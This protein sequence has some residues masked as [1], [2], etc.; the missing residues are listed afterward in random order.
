MGYTLGFIGCGN[1][2]EA[3]LSG[4]RGGQMEMESIYGC[5][6]LAER[7]A[8]FAGMGAEILTLEAMMQKTDRLVL[9]I[10]PLQSLD[11]LHK[12]AAHWR[13]GQSLLSIVAGLNCATME[14]ILGEVPLV[15][16]MPNTPSLQGEGMSGICA[17][18]FAG[19]EDIAFAE[20]L[21]GV[22]GQTVKLEETMMDALTAVS[23]SGPA[24]F[25]LV[26]EAFIAAAEELGFSTSSATE[27]VLQVMR[28]SLAMLSAG[29]DSPE[30][31]RKKVS[32][33][34]GTTVA[35]IEQLEHYRLREA[36]RAA[37]QTAEQR[38]KEISGQL[39]YNAN[40]KE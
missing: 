28:G 37:L 14:S 15:R 13:E 31:L 8:L 25:F 24:Y 11:I 19:F 38:S 12:C 36:F 3:I 17:G 39:A 40:L 1:M 6:L 27:M 22:L 23:G 20:Q 2:A 26:A 16:V 32:S 18:Q 33:P 34:G 29:G 30:Q 10:K 35:A 21:F 5:D 9:A 4:L 7:C